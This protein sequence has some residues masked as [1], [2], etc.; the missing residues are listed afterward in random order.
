MIDWTVGLQ[1]GD[2]LPLYHVAGTENI[3]DLLTKEHDIGTDQ[4]TI[5][6]V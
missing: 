1:P 5:G 4:V 6:S 2:K 3:A